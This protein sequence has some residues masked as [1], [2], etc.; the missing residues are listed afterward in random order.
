MQMLSK[1][2]VV[3][4]VLSL[5]TNPDGVLVPLSCCFGNFEIPLD[6]TRDKVITTSQG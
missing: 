2:N 1:G 3:E 4:C 5:S 6:H